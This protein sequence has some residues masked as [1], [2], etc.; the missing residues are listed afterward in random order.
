ME[1]PSQSLPD[2]PEFPHFS[3]DRIPVAFRSF[4]HQLS[5]FPSFRPVSLTDKKLLKSP[6]KGFFSSADISPDG[7]KILVSKNN[8]DGSQGFEEYGINSMDKIRERRFGE[9][10]IS[11][12]KYH[13]NNELIGI[14]TLRGLK[15]VFLFNLQESKIKE[16]AKVLNQIKI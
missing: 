8:L 13:N 2:V 11:S 9:G 14:K 16:I 15:T 10:V 3:R 7:K 1:P 5:P 12:L 4:R 6:L